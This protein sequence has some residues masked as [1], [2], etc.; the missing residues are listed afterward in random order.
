MKQALVNLH[1]AA[2]EAQLDFK[3]TGNIHDEIQAEVLE[4][5]TEQFGKL[6]V[7]AIERAGEH[8]NLRCP[9]TGDYKVG[10]NWSL[11]H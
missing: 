1:R 4:A 7:N 9:T 11:T 3:L 6:A 8:F 10:D 5:H 2:T